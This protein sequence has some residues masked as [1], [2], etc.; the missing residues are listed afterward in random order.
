LKAL[1]FYKNTQ[2]YIAA[3]QIY[4]GEKRLTAL[5]AMYPNIVNILSAFCFF[6]E[7]RMMI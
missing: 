6:L 7:S 3:G 1:G 5:R 4:G 2:I